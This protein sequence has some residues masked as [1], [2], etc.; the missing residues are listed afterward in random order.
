MRKSK[1]ERTREG[2][3]LLDD[4]FTLAKS[5]QNGSEQNLLRNQQDSVKGEASARRGSQQSAVDQLWSDGHILDA[6]RNSITSDKKQEDDFFDSSPKAEASEDHM[7]KYVR[8]ELQ[9]LET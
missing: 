7:I 2:E 9:R 6:R 4:A 8:D 1:E 5:A 3:R